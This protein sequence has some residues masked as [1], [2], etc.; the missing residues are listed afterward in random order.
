VLQSTEAVVARGETRRT[1]A[2]T[3][4]PGTRFGWNIGAQQ[5]VLGI[6]LP[7]TREDAETATSAFAYASWELPFAH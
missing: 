6:A 5:I 1:Q 7:I 4:S 2:V 3:I